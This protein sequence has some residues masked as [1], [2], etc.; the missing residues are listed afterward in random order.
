M[1]PSLS[2]APSGRQPQQSRKDVANQVL[3]LTE[4][5][6][7]DSWSSGKQG[8]SFKGGDQIEAAFGAY[9][10]NFVYRREAPCTVG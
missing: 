10:A 6:T 3:L 7:V 4:D 8:S 1:I 2:N 9:L 5:A